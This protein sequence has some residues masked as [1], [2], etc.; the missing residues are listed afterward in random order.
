MYLVM[1]FCGGKVVKFNCESGEIASCSGNIHNTLISGNVDVVEGIAVALFSKKGRLFVQIGSQSWD[2]ASEN[3]EMFYAHDIDKKTT[4]FKI[5]SNDNEVVFTRK[6]WWSE[7]PGF[8]PFEPEMDEDEDYLAY[9][10]TIF[11]NPS[12]QAHLLKSWKS[13]DN[14]EVDD[15]FS[16]SKYSQFS[17]LILNYISYC[18]SKFHG[19]YLSALA[20]S[21][22]EMG[23]PLEAQALIYTFK[24][25]GKSKVWRTLKTDDFDEGSEGRLWAGSQ[26]WVGQTLPKK[27][28]PADWWFDPLE[29]MFYV[30]IDRKPLDE[31]DAVYPG[32]CALTPCR[33][34]QYRTCIE[35]A[36][37]EPD[38]NSQSMLQVKDLFQDRHQDKK[39]SDYITDIYAEEALLYSRF[40]GRDNDVVSFGSICRSLIPEQA[41]SLFSHHLLLIGGYPGREELS[42][43]IDSHLLFER[44]FDS[45]PHHFKMLEDFTTLHAIG[46][47]EKHPK[48]AFQCYIED[49]FGGLQYSRN[50]PR[51]MNYGT[52]HNEIFNLSPNS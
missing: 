46:E 7:I 44:P 31:F 2:L 11:S 34:W 25:K 37:F 51:K 52:F 43:L 20:Q 12:A 49:Q 15:T 19:K 36:Q 30:R 17:T 40:W 16:I 10:H 9:L 33:V 5:Y 28:K 23:Q 14:G 45:W 1:P 29:I 48:G 39:D 13:N 4:E 32:W 8:E 18:Q 35:L 3:I 27:A 38:L 22:A 24:N 47:W 41:L 26:V 42:G 6:A 50:L 21:L